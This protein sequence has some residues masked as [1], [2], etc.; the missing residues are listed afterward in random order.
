MAG[1]VHV[2][3]EQLPRG[4]TLLEHNVIEQVLYSPTI[5]ES[6]AVGEMMG[7]LWS[8]N[9]GSGEPV[10][11]AL[12]EGDFDL[13]ANTSAAA[14][15]CATLACP[16]DPYTL[17]V[18]TPTTSARE[19]HHRPN[20]V[21]PTS[22]PVGAVP[23]APSSSP[24]NNGTLPTSR[25]EPSFHRYRRGTSSSARASSAHSLRGARTHSR[26]RSRSP[27][28]APSLLSS[29]T[30]HVADTSSFTDNLTTLP[31]D[32][33]P[34][35]AAALACLDTESPQD[36]VDEERTEHE[37]S[38]AFE[39][40][41][42]TVPTTFP[43]EGLEPYIFSNSGSASQLPVFICLVAVSSSDGKVQAA[44]DFAAASDADPGNYDPDAILEYHVICLDGPTVAQLNAGGNGAEDGVS[45]PYSF[46]FPDVQFYPATQ[47]ES[48]YGGFIPPGF[49][50]QPGAV[51]PGGE[52]TESA[53][54]QLS[55]VTP[56]RPLVDLLAKSAPLADTY[57]FERAD[58][59]DSKM[60]AMFA[61]NRNTGEVDLVI[62]SEQAENLNPHTGLPQ[63]V[64][65][66]SLV[67]RGVIVG[68][69]FKKEVAVSHLDASGIFG[70]P[71]TDLVTVAA[72]DLGLDSA[73]TEDG[74]PDPGVLCSAQR[75]V[76]SKGN[77]GEF[78]SNTYPVEEVHKVALLDMLVANL[79]RTAQNLLVSRTGNKLIPIDH[80]LSLPDF[81]H[82]E[83]L[84]FVWLQWSQSKEPLV[85]KFRDYLLADLDELVSAALLEGLGLSAA[86]VLT[87]LMCAAWV[88]A[89]VKS[90]KSPHSVGTA[91][92]RDVSARSVDDAGNVYGAPSVLE[93]LRDRALATVAGSHGVPL[94]ALLDPRT[95][96]ALV[97][98]L[99]LQSEYL[100]CF[101]ELAQLY[102]RG[103]TN[104]ASSQP[105][106]VGTAAGDF[107][108]AQY[109]SEVEAGE[110]GSD[111]PG[112]WD[113][114]L[115]MF[116]GTHDE[117]P[118]LS[119]RACVGSFGY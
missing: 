25:S 27:V 16:Y 93:Q 90:G 22:V 9:F 41:Y 76:S 104:V 37:P 57:D 65:E 85:A 83:E 8:L 33:S 89:G 32:T 115:P 97:N 114:P 34:M 2:C 43:G 91:M 64:G 69:A 86:S 73:A 6:V 103:D 107:S 77:A 81:R 15:N 94:H 47:W 101:S 14:V 49:P 29:R 98:N 12:E 59:Q 108:P 113:V 5:M 66:E 3:V 40:E 117:I 63:E 55:A 56:S 31:S 45:P 53:D 116:T 1:H 28:S 74:D 105:S 112:A 60:G 62:K 99:A 106:D 80:G 78:G 36:P 50:L 54:P 92:C 17:S 75:Y 67:R 79:D 39:F 30:V 19:D 21:N 11:G 84:S 24:L 96:T 20:V 95:P 46:G 35:Y 87:F 68:D 70:V 58:L 23:A 82:L 109:P 110:P 61:V 88:K 4:N 100:Q 119:P 38:S 52:T 71:K 48:Y 26:R 18:T 42:P 118:I 102:F 72:A 13:C 51:F 10:C 111:D 44:S 7:G